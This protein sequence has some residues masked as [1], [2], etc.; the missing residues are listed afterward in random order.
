MNPH[1]TILLRCLR[2]P[3]ELV[4][5]DGQD[6]EALLAAARGAKVL[7][8]LA[9]RARDAGIDEQ[10]T[11]RFRDQF[12]AAR[13][14]AD[15]YR[16]VITWE[17]GC[18]QR[19]LAPLKVPV[20]FLKGAAYVLADLPAGRGRLVNDVDAMVPKAALESAEQLLLSSGWRAIKIDAYDQRY[21]RQWMHEL[22][23]LEHKQR[24]VVIDLHHTILPETGRLKPDAAKLFAAS[25]GVSAPTNHS[26]PATQQ[27]VPTHIDRT[28]TGGH[29]PT[30][31]LR[32][33]SPCDMI[34]H[35]AAH[36]FQ[37]GDLAGGLRDLLDLDDLLRDF[38]GSADRPGR[39]P[40]FWRTLVPRAVEM[41]LHRPLFYALRFT[42]RLLDTPVPAEVMREASQAG[43][44]IWPTAPLMDFLASRAMMPDFGESKKLGAASARWML[45][46]RSH[47]LRMP[48]LLLAQHLGRKAL[49]RFSKEEPPQPRT[50]EEKNIDAKRVA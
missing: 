35:S 32:V 36:L 10:L 39:E 28:E 24:K 33:L 19:V 50:H 21:Y 40:D 23:P 34:L 30:H 6:I 29:S 44:P 31:P 1:D 16:R 4:A 43:G 8:K 41:D 3:R 38:G 17:A 13:V 37:D 27:H 15:H 12:I 2:D 26:D 48:P 20:V 5:L 18:I 14:L 45:Y 47:W 9:Q 7:S 49:R 46:V 25:R 42:S 22:P 11:P